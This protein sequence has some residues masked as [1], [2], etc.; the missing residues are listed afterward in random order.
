MGCWISNTCLPIEGGAVR[1]HG[2][3]APCGRPPPDHL[4]LL[5]SCPLGAAMCTHLC[6]SST[7]KQLQ[8]R[9]VVRPAH[10]QCL[11]PVAYAWAA[12]LP[13]RHN[14]V[15]HVIGRQ[16]PIPRS[17]SRPQAGMAAPSPFCCLQATLALTAGTASCCLHAVSHRIPC[18]EARVLVLK[19]DQAT[20]LT[21]VCLFLAAECREWHPQQGRPLP[22]CPR[23]VLLTCRELLLRKPPRDAQRRALAMSGHGACATP[24]AAAAAAGLLSI[25]NLVGWRGYRH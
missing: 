13:T 21:G 2:R 11:V 16:R 7:T 10:K 24:N 25:T 15:Q 9:V 17:S 6:A 22:C 5:L 4:Q 3:P 8:N 19:P 18:F 20:T 14:L 23:R 12:F 1:G